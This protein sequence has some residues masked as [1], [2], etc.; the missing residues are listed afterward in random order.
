[1]RLVVFGINHWNTPVQIRER[2]ALSPQ[3]TVVLLQNWIH[4]FTAAELVPLST[5]NRTEFYIATENGALPE[6]DDVFAF[7]CENKNQNEDDLSTLQECRDHFFLY[8]NAEACE[9]LFKVISSLDSMVPGEPQILSQVKSAYQLAADQ[10]T[11]GPITHAAFQAALRTAKRIATETEL[12]HHRVSIPSV[13]VVDF[14]LGLFEKLSDKKTVILG[15]GEMA[16]E[17]LRYLTDNGAQNIEVVNRSTE[18]AQQLATEFHGTVSDWESRNRTLEQADIIVAATSADH[19]VFTPEQYRKASVARRGRP[20]FILDLSVPRNIDP[21]LARF[22]DVYLYSIDDLHAACGRNRA[23]RDREIPR[24][25]KI[26]KQETSLFLQEMRRRDSGDLIRQL[27]LAW[28]EVKEEELKRLFNKC[29]GL[30]EKTATEI[31]YAFDRIVNKLLHPPMESLKDESVLGTP[32]KLMEAMRR[33]FR[34]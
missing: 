14:A 1:M 25:D 15:A 11:T 16:R 10:G 34:L 8:D 28:N 30:D 17:T 13:A 5:C 3:E 7:L 22:P 9:H 26:V 18:R 33:L 24:A 6:P 21:A 20:L 2:F 12:F 27:R 29:P 19:Y 32:G 4:R 23:A 31:Q